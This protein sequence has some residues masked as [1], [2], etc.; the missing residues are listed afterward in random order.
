MENMWELLVVEFLLGAFLGWF[1]LCRRRDAI[2]PRWVRWVSLVPFAVV[3]VLMGGPYTVTTLPEMIASFEGELTA[4]AIEHFEQFVAERRMARD[5]SIVCHFLGVAIGMLLAF[6]IPMA[7][8]SERWSL[9]TLK[10]DRN[11]KVEKPPE[12]S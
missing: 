10:L 4:D 1:L 2:Q 11:W 7:A 12:R 8:V 6:K 5:E 9:T 3:I